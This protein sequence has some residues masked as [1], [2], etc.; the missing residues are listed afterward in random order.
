MLRSTLKE[1]SAIFGTLAIN[2]VATIYA[3]FNPIV[4]KELFTLYGISATGLYGYSQQQ[5]LSDTSTADE[6][7][8]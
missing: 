1:H 6:D 4:A 5:R 2:F 8:K 7:E 3:I